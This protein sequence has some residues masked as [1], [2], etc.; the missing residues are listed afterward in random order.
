MFERIL[1]IPPQQ[2]FTGDQP[3]YYVAFQK[4]R[5]YLV[6]NTNEPL[7]RVVTGNIVLDILQECVVGAKACAS[8]VYEM[9]MPQEGVL[10][11]EHKDT[12]WVKQW[13]I[14]LLTPLDIL[15]FRLLP[16]HAQEHVLL[17]DSGSVGHGVSLT[18]LE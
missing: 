5:Y 13:N 16:S 2:V 11:D 9:V 10:I 1:G 15:H 12:S 7:R 3:L 18:V 14:T 4:G 6:N 17:W 8:C